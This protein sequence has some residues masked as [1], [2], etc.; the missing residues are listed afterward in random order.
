[1]FL[2]F[3]SVQRTFFDHHP[4]ARVLLSVRHVHRQL[5]S[6]AGRTQPPAKD[7]LTLGLHRIAQ[8][9]VRQPALREVHQSRRPQAERRPSKYSLLAWTLLQVRD[10]GP[11][12]RARHRSP[13]LDRLPDVIPGRSRTSADQDD[14]LLHAED[15][16]RESCRSGRQGVD[17]DDDFPANDGVRSSIADDV[18]QFGEQR[19]LLFYVGVF[20]RR[21]VE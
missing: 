7:L 17:A 3:F 10:R 15:Q 8:R 1:M 18:D 19:S 12:P 4:R 5:R 16:Q 9:R 20:G 6:S 14:R 2:C 13:R 11:P 21:S